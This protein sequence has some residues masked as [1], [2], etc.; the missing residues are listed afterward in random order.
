MLV[1]AYFGSDRQKI[2]DELFK[3]RHTFIVAAN[4]KAI[5]S[6]GLADGA[7]G[8]D[9][10]DYISKVRMAENTIWK[11]SADDD[12]SKQLAVATASIEDAFAPLVRRKV[13]KRRL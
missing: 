13:G 4:E 5:F 6:D 7:E 12:F 2:F 11:T 8:K 10:S 9:R 1:K 3:L